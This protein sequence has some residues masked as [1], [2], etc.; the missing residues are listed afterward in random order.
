MHRSARVR[1]GVC[2]AGGA[3]LVEPMRAG[4][5]LM[6]AACGL[7]TAY[8]VDCD[9][10]RHTVCSGPA[11]PADFPDW[12]AAMNTWAAGVRAQFGL[13]NSLP[14]Y[15]VPAIQWTQ[16]RVRTRVCACVRFYACV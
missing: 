13:N 7:A 11:S 14:V 2:S 16:V 15:S 6:L 8:T 5:L 9:T 12:L 3:G 1:G 10:E 4:S